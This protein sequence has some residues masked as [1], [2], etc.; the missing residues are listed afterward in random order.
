M[1]RM[2]RQ[3]SV[4]E[5]WATWPAMDCWLSGG[6]WTS[7]LTPCD[8]GGETF[9]EAQGAARWQTAVIEGPNR[10]GLGSVSVNLA[11]QD[12]GLAGRLSNQGG[13]VGLTGNVTLD[14]AGR[15]QLDLRLGAQGGRQPPAWIGS[16]ASRQRDGTY[17]LRHGGQL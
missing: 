15:Y 1:S 8:G 12:G 4:P 17:V 3:N 9:R 11:L 14:A 6:R 7:T 2:S 13:D 10:L 5:I 16:M